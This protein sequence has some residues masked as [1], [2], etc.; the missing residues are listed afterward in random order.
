MWFEVASLLDPW[1]PPRDWGDAPA[2]QR[3]CPQSG[4]PWEKDCWGRLPQWR[5]LTYRQVALRDA[6]V[7][8]LAADAKACEWE[9]EVKLE[10]DMRRTQ[11]DQRRL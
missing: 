8:Q 6:T 3:G 1:G 4:G 9:E 5:G 7:K 10:R 2:P 11:A